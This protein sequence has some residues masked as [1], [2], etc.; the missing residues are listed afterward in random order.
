[1]NAITIQNVELPVVEIEAQ[2]VVTL[3]MVDAVHQRP[4]GTAKRNFQGHRLRFIEGE[5]FFQKSSDEIRTNSP[6]AIPAALRRNDVILLTESGYLMLVKSFT[7]DLAWEVQRKLVNSYFRVQSKHADPMRLLN[8][9]AA[10]RGLLLSYTEK[11]LV[12]EGAVTEERARADRAEDNLHVVTEKVEE[13]RPAVAALDRIASTDG[14]L[15]VTDAAK[16]L[17]LQRKFLVAWLLANGWVYRRDGG[18]LVAYQ[19]KLNAKLLVHKYYTFLRRDGSQEVST[20]AHVTA[21]GLAKLAREVPGAVMP[22]P[23]LL[24]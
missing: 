17:Q 24:G 21:K 6:N 3:A 4:E 7:D 20:R 9:P 5:D 13:M 8:D 18:E 10:M 1:M 11:V 16:T 22:Q 15:C 2:R 14:A 23:R 12:L 19:D